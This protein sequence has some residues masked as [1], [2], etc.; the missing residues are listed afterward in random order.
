MLRIDTLHMMRTRAVGCFSFGRVTGRRD[1][2]PVLTFLP[3][4][5]DPLILLHE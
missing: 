2:P 3:T 1:K 4:E 5:A